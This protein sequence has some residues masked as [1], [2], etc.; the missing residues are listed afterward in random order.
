M[1]HLEFVNQLDKIGVSLRG[2]T[3]EGT[4]KR[5]EIVR[6]FSGNKEY[7]IKDGFDLRWEQRNIF[8]DDPLKE[9][10]KIAIDMDTWKHSWHNKI[11]PEN[12]DKFREII[13][14]KIVERAKEIELLFDVYFQLQH[15]LSTKECGG[16]V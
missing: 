7:I 3:I 12:Y 11:E 13:Q 2:T 15:E 1:D 6:P 8:G 4:A 5:Y 10:I 9:L 14:G 16:V